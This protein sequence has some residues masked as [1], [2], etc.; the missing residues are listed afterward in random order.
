MKYIILFF[1]ILLLYNC[2]INK[3]VKHHGIHFLEKK[4]VKLELT[5]SN[6]NDVR[7]LL[8]PP[9]TQNIFDKDIWIY[10]ERKTTVSD[11]KSFGRKKLLVNN[12]LILEFNN[13]GILI[14]KNFYD[15]NSIKK[16]KI[17]ENETY[18]LNKEENF[19][20]SVLSSLK[21]KINDPLGKKTIK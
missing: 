11:F 16:L 14:K 3:V 19:L 8:G 6:V 4:Q 17:N 7:N 20:K 12:V 18:V 15:K 2:S 9:S 5:K 10:I 13:K 1:L 21:K